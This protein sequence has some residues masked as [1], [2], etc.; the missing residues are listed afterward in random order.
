MRYQS[1]SSVNTDGFRAG[2]EIGDA[3]Q[4]IAPEVVL[5]FASVTYQDQFTDL[6]A[7]LYGALR[8][9]KPLIFGGT[10]DGVYERARVAHHG[11]CALGINSQGTV[12]WTTALQRGV[13]ADSY[14]A[15]RACT[16]LA[17]RQLE[18]PV[19]F[20][21][22]FADGVKA[23]GSQIVEGTSSV[24]GI[25]FL[26]GLAGD[27]RKFERSWILVNGEACQDA[28]GIL[29]ASGPLPFVVNAAS[30][31]TPV[32]DVGLIEQCYG[33]QIQRISGMTPLV[34]MR[35]Q[36]G[37]TP[38]ATDLG[39][40][41]LAT[42]DPDASGRFYLRTPSRMEPTTGA[43]TMFGSVQK[44]ASVRVCTASV[45]NVLCGVD[46]AMKGVANAPFTPAAALVVS[47]AG[48]R[49]LLEDRSA[50]EVQRVFAAIGRE[51][52]L[53]GMPSFGEISPFRKENGTYTPT[54]F[55]NTTFVVCLF[56][57]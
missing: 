46:D 33:S 48:R 34:F 26:G 16:L 13:G 41:P 38:S 7:G 2:S 21:F 55:H 31:W 18:G 53:A 57:T 22:T 36:V 5:L 25:P 52:P 44:N 35:E 42:Y 30:G 32:G 15:A 50:E 23:D 10:S 4:A 40:M 45:Q 19:D 1:F 37:K 43:V 27:D 29:A 6:F 20:A 11:V 54:Y 14:A 28:V 3:L 12:R 24:L 47:C 8:P 17:S 49:W 9:T 56:G 51:I 39:I